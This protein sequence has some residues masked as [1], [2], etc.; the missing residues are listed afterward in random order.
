MKT[1]I[2]LSG[3]EKKNL[4]RICQQLSDLARV[5]EP[6]DIPQHRKQYALYRE[7]I[8]LFQDVVARLNKSHHEI[9]AHGC[10]TLFELAGR[11][12]LELGGEAEP[13][14]NSLKD[15][16]HQ[17]HGPFLGVSDEGSAVNVIRRAALGSPK[18][19][20]LGTASPMVVGV[21]HDAERL[22]AVGEVAV[23]PQEYR[24][25]RLGCSGSILTSTNVGTRLNLRYYKLRPTIEIRR[26]SSVE[27][28]VDDARRKARELFLPFT[29]TPDRNP[30]PITILVRFEPGMRFC[31][32]K[33]ILSLLENDPQR[34]QYSNPRIHRFG[35][36]VQT[37]RGGWGVKT[38]M[39]SIKM[40]SD[41]G[42]PVVAISG[43]VLSEAE[44]KISM[45]GLLQY[46]Q[47]EIAQKMMDYASK[48]GVSIEPRNMVDP[49]TVYR[50]VWASLQ[51]ARNMGLELGKY[52]LFPLTIPQAEQVM[53]GVQECF[54]GW[55][56]AP[57]FYIDFPNV[58][59]RKIYT[60][61]TI[62]HGIREWLDIVASHEIPIVLIDTADKDRGRRLLKES[63]AD[64]V[65]ILEP[66]EIESINRYALSLKIR[67]LWAG[68]I[69]L[70][71]VFELGKLNVF[72]IY[73]T[74]SATR[75]IPVSGGYERDPLIV[76]VKE[77]TMEG[78][79]ATLLMLQSGF[80]VTKL[81][82]YGKRDE[83]RQL[84]RAASE[85][86]TN[87]APEVVGSQFEEHASELTKLARDA[88]RFHYRSI[89]YL[90]KD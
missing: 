84:E 47:P 77:P 5:E 17:S 62:T 72:G 34:M 10:E 64:E 44:D 4:D 80:L 16:D 45:P 68:G 50:S 15:Y 89:G 39:R 40:A 54:K 49:D 11:A 24:D 78:V 71:Q 18:M 41:I 6:L 7:V 63:A 82:S 74:S 48:L 13:A 88:W 20:V 83:A 22:A 23:G 32:R 90:G 38:A 21:S 75:L 60:M 66:N 87:L 55:T 14:S 28:A 59:Q 1:S 31:D 67:I 8:H 30:R 42:I 19:T 61:R 53:A 25:I 29:Q 37:S 9:A 69:S 65:G 2:A 73:V 27:R 57:A 26:G 35:L 46:F 52:G 85:F 36:L 12:I 56:A 70:R 76:S 43:T 86:L 3:R 33:E 81:H 79:S 51:T 58:G